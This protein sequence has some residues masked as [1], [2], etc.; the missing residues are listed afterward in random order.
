MVMDRT[1]MSKDFNVYGPASLLGVI[2]YVAFSILG[3]KIV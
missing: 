3:I 1:V 2:E